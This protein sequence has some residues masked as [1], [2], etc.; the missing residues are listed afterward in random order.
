M[1]STENTRELETALQETVQED[2]SLVN[3][4]PPPDVAASPNT[5]SKKRKNKKKKKSYAAVTSTDV[6][7]PQENNEQVVSATNEPLRSDEREA[8]A[9][10]AIT[11]Q[12]L[13]AKPLPDHVKDAIKEVIKASSLDVCNIASRYA[14]A[15]PEKTTEKKAA[16]QPQ[17]PKEK[18][19][20]EKQIPL[21]A[22]TTAAISAAVAAPTVDVQAILQQ[23]KPTEPTKSTYS[24]KP[25]P[26]IVPAPVS[27]KV[28]ER[29]SEPVVQRPKPAVAVPHAASEIT[30]SVAQPAQQSPQQPTQPSQ[31]R[32]P[33]EPAARH[34][35]SP[36]SKKKNC[37]I[38]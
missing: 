14:V 22:A 11:A 12:Q 30:P 38:L 36:G 33:Y 9:A 4:T 31:Q 15:P 29:L 34:R 2:T 3:E 1:S 7:P 20:E 17:Q 19:G 21:S 25:L 18:V 10:T 35:R 6:P 28:E 27:K 16:K 37:I 23:A 32:T 5:G 8:A 13:V 26:Q 24:D